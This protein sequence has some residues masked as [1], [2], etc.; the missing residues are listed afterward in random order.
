[1]AVAKTIEVIT[2]SAKGIE[3]AVQSGIAKVGETVKN[4]EGAWVKDTKAVV[5]NG[6][7]TEWRVTLAVTFIVD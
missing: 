2:S 5:R 7:V 6:S 3:D 1:M 4:I